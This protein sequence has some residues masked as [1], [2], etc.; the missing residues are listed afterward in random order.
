MVNVR[1]CKVM[2]VNARNNEAITVNGLALEDV[3][4]FIYLGATV[5]KQGGGEE[6]IKARLG[7]ARGAFLRLNR[8]WNSSSVSRRTKIRLYKTLVKPVLMYGCETQKMNEGDAKRIDVF[9]NRCLRRIMKIKQQDKIS[10]GELLKRAK[11]ERLNE[12]VRRRRW[13]FIGHILRKQSD[14][15]CIKALT[16][17]FFW[18]LFIYIFHNY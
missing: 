4:R 7:K 12:E 8:V 13:R 9:Q 16:F 10:N 14:N 1:K 5:C 15:D 17:F 6:D 3:E 11:V 18:H 2:R